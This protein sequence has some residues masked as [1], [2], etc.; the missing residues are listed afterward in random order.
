M[1]MIILIIIIMIIIII[2]MMIII[3]IIIIIIM[4]IIIIIVKSI[5]LYYVGKA[6]FVPV[7]ILMNTLRRLKIYLL[8]GEKSLC[9]TEPLLFGG[10]K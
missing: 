3:I 6:C 10:I 9:F 8:K 2:M 4:I 5:P 1:I 7:Y